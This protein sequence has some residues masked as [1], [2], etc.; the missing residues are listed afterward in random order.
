MALHSVT[1]YMLR[2]M[3]YDAG[4]ENAGP[5]SRAVKTTG[6][7]RK[8]SPRRRRFSAG[9]TVFL[10]FWSV[11]F[12]CGCFHCSSSL[13]A[14]SGE[15]LDDADADAADDSLPAGCWCWCCC[16][17]TRSS[18]LAPVKPARH[19]HRPCASHSAPF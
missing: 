15:L 13:K 1:R 5:S 14:S 12:Q 10:P 7:D 17:C 9:P 6:P 16:R 3:K 2:A 8:R 19:K 18:H 11:N 4:L